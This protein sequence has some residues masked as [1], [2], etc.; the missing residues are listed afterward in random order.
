MG[1]F[2]QVIITIAVLVVLI[3]N[4]RKDRSDGRDALGGGGTGKGDG[5]T[6]ETSQ[7]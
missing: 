3:R 4:Y 7:H 1:E 2:L 5:S 6:R